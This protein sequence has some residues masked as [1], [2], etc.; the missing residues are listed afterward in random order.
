MVK[1]LP[2]WLKKPGMR[3]TLYRRVSASVFFDGK[4]DNVI[5]E[6]KA[7]QKDYPNCDVEIDHEYYGYDGGCDV[8]VV[9]REDRP[10]TKEEHE[11]RIR[12]YVEEEE[13]REAARNLKKAKAKA[14]TAAAERALYKKLKEKYEGTS[15]DDDSAYTVTHSS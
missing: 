6:L 15:S 8:W 3:Q 10:E 5:K 14:R 13:K 11:E 12:M 2:A 4:I 1:K 9:F 7:I